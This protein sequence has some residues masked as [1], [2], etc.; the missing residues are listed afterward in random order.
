M[1]A[2]R[3]RPARMVCAPMSTSGQIFGK[4]SLIMKLA[5]GGQGEI[6]L[7]RLEGAAGFEKLVVIKRL[8]P[9]LADDAHFAKMLVDE[10]RIVARID[11]VNVCQ[12]HELGQVAGLYYLAM[13]YLEGVPLSSIL[14]QAANDYRKLD[15][16]LVTAILQQ[17]C[18]G[19]HHAH[20]LKDAS[21]E[22]IGLVHR[23]VSP[24]NLFV[25]VEGYVKVLDFG[26]AKARGMESRTRTGTIKG[27]YEYM[28]P[29]Q[30]LRRP[31]DR[32]SDIFSLGIV[33]FETLTVRR[34]FYRES[35]FE[36]FRA[37]TDEPLPSLK[38]QRRDAPDELVAVLERALCRDAE[39]RF[40]TARD[41]RVALLDATA[42]LG[43]P[44]SQEEIGEYVRTH[45][46]G[47]LALRQNAIASRTSGPRSGSTP[48]DD[49]TVL[50]A[51]D[52]PAARAETVPMRVPMSDS[53]DI[54]FDESSTH[55]AALSADPPAPHATRRPLLWAFLVVLAMAAGMVS[56]VIIRGRQMQQA[57]AEERDAGP[58]VIRPQDACTAPLAARRAEA[59]RC[60]QAH[61]PERQAPHS[62]WKV[63]LIIDEQGR[64][65]RARLSADESVDNA[66]PEGLGNPSLNRCI[67]DIARQADFAECAGRAR[68][69]DFRACDRF[70]DDQDRDVND[71]S[72]CIAVKIDLQ[73]T[74]RQ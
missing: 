40:A 74:P 19:L 34:M 21:G 48:G 20:E 13:E 69:D 55:H 38:R 6:Y 27:K 68:K 49:W 22:L 44:Y 63:R 57:S 31:L 33:L 65:R 41:F 12:V 72:R 36:V 50:S 60:F 47:E 3:V 15:I 66:R 29:E 23:D 5:A 30:V 17:A 26:V 73:V 67:E 25:T 16:R 70:L 59:D 4:Y 46:A 58:A 9:H 62:R 37:I 53:I 1:G 18:E 52:S 42:S 32:R 39:G 28:S 51:V 24:S 43:A 7:A 61:P 10:A 35:E 45:F 71:V 2:G 64:V 56:A 11:H 14:Q 8:L 54:G